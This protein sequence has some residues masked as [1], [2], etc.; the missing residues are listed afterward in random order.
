MRFGTTASLRWP[1]GLHA[2]TA[3][4][5]ALRSL[6]RHRGR[7]VITLCAIAVGT[8]ALVL[9]GGL[10]R[11]IFM[12][13]GEAIIRSQ[14]GH[15]Q[16]ASRGFFSHGSRS[17]EQYLLGDIEAKKAR[18]AELNE[19]S[20]AMA[21]IRFSGLLGN[22]RTEFPIVAE[23]IEPGH[24]AALGSSLVVVVGRNL[25]DRDEAGLLIGTG[26]AK[27]LGLRP[28]DP[29][30][31]LV[32]TLRGGI[33]TLDVEVVGVFQ[34]FSKD[35]DDHA[36]KLTIKAA[37]LLLDTEEANAIVVGLNRTEDTERL[38]HV[39]R[40]ADWATD[41]EVKTWEELNDFYSKTVDMYDGF[42]AV[43]RIIILVMVL[44]GVANAVNMSV[45]E[46]T[47][48]FG[49]MRA[50]GNRKGDV[51]VLVLAEAM[52]TAIVGA[53]IGV[54]LGILVAVLVS[55]IGIPMPPPPNSNMGYTARIQVV[56]S[57]IGWAVAIACMATIVASLPATLRVSRLSIVDALRRQL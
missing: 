14:S 2:R 49:T 31:L 46:R 11:D 38:A 23:G 43:F 47:G 29:A 50:L 13:L 45:L 40:T 1:S 44:L 42:F 20:I 18:L 19:V 17:T 34:S 32:S 56:P 27:A 37:Q 35:Y 26:V 41:L 8:A 55:R 57:V 30:T 6:L 15:I 16:I 36:V 4:Q 33:N 5:I 28:G 9:T 48:E 22:G 3:S 12:Q 24:E 52:M 54:A 53:A 21:R 25:N 39:I 10:L 51:I 7:T